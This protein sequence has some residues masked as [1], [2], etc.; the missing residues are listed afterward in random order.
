MAAT[1]PPIRKKIA[2][3]RLLPRKR[4]ERILDMIAKMMAVSELRKSLT[5]IAPAA[6]G[7]R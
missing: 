3:S 5:I 2:M 4:P 6:I 7:V 1:T